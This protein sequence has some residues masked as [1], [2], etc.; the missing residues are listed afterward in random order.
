MPDDLVTTWDQY[1]AFANHHDKFGRTEESQ[2]DVKA[3]HDQAGSGGGVA[4]PAGADSKQPQTAAGGVQND[5]SG[6]RGA[7]AAT[8]RPVLTTSASTDDR[9]PSGDGDAWAQWEL[10]EMEDLLGDVRGHLV[11]YSTR[12]L[13]AEDLAN[14]FL[15][16]QERILPL[17]IYD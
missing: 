9:K 7:G 14:N 11:L 17:V 4:G 1:K 5:M 3:T 15:F 16:N 12:F 10:D 13:E 2:H 8:S 6:S